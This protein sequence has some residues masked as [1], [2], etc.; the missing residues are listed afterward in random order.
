VLPVP[1]PAL[2]VSI[3][4]P[5]TPLPETTFPAPATVPPI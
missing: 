3:A 2:V 4:I 1:V 5:S